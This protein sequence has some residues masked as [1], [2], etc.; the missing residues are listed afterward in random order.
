MHQAGPGQCLQ[1]EVSPWNEHNGEFLAVRK[2]SG[3]SVF[4]L[5]NPPSLSNPSDASASFSVPDG[6]LKK[7]TCCAFNP[8]L[9]GELAAAGGPGTVYLVDCS[10]PAHGS[11]VSANEP[12]TESASFS[13]SCCEFGHHPRLVL[14]GAGEAL[15]MA[16][17]R[18]RGARQTRYAFAEGERVTSLRCSNDDRALAV[19][20]T[21]GVNLFDARMLREPVL[22]WPFCEQPCDRRSKLDFPH[23]LRPGLEKG[24]LAIIAPCTRQGSVYAFCCDWRAGE[25]DAAEELLQTPAIA[26]GPGSLMRHGTLGELTGFRADEQNGSVYALT[27]RLALHRGQMECASMN[28]GNGPEEPLPLN[29]FFPEPTAAERTPTKGAASVEL[30]CTWSRRMAVQGVLPMDLGCLQHSGGENGRDEGRAESMHPSR[31]RG[32]DR[33]FPATL[34]E[35]RSA[36]NDGEAYGWGTRGVYSRFCCPANMWSEPRQF[37]EA[38]SKTGHGLTS[39]QEAIE[40]AEIDEEAAK[41]EWGSHV[42]L[43]KEKPFSDVARGA[44][45]GAN[46]GM[47][48]RLLQRWEE[49][50]GHLHADVVEE[51]K[52]RETKR[53]KES[54]H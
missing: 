14:F 49:A 41:A 27:G 25:R 18:Q 50:E 8:Y 38:R 11:L 28:D 35:K 10:R 32:S 6:G 31:S 16:D 17:L 22:R 26:D 46:V 48:Q 34:L 29:L 23:L 40:L 21:G 20:T 13:P 9:P 7:L 1:L 44:K 2:E 53:S 4:A 43:G 37:H 33:P 15:R 19:V 54:Q 36:E 51:R 5:R 24:R 30:N 42:L 3:L 39:S 12:T 45:S 47:A 52:G